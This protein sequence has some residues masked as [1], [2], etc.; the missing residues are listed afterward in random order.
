MITRE[1]IKELAVKF[2]TA[3]DNIAREY[4]QHL[5]L[6][7]LNQ[8]KGSQKLLFKGGTALRII[9][10]S[11]RFSE[12]LDFSAIN[13]G[14]VTVAEIN[15]LIDDVLYKMLAEGI[16]VDKTLNPG[17]AGE[18]SGGYFASINLKMLDFSSEL[19]IQVS[20]RSPDQALGNSTMVNNSFVAPYLIYY[21]DEKILVSEKI[22]ALLFRKKPRD[23][24]DLF[25]ILRDPLL[26]KNIPAKKDLKNEIFKIID[27]AGDFEKEL[28]IFLPISFHP[29][30]KDFKE[31]L[32][33]EVEI[34]LG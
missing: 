18:T 2:Q 24:F 30:L 26:V 6:S 4:C 1:F 19:Q 32:K 20:F 13:S 9:F 28:K 21:L 14:Q 22:A 12:D 25:F 34:H 27:E 33:R 3:E 16:Q 7:Y 15:Q 17:T 11:P 5:F 31:R 29:V 23:F 8:L 10:Q